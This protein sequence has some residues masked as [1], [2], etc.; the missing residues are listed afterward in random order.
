[1]KTLFIDTHYQDILVYLYE[2]QKLLKKNIIQ[3]TKSTSIDTMPLIVKTMDECNIKPNELG[4]IAVIKGPGSF[5]GIR[6]GV[7]IA[8]VMAYAL[9]IPI[10]SLSSLDLIGLN[11][12]KPAYIAVKENNGAF[13]GKYDRSKVTDVKYLK[14]SEYLIFKESNK[15][16]EDIKIDSTKLINYLLKL[17]PENVYNVNPWYVKSIEA[18][19]DQRS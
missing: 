11:L 8:K 15:V 12:D 16:V 19:N 3:N 1:M 13:V 18:L 14:K 6:L 2:D 4:L 5:T 10:V 9:N 7:T 17:T